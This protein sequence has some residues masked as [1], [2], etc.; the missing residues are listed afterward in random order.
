MLWFVCLFGKLILVGF[1][2]VLGWGGLLVL[3][4]GFCS[5]TGWDNMVCL[6]VF[7]VC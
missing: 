6:I 3:D 7:G 1:G 2:C 5:G 4:V